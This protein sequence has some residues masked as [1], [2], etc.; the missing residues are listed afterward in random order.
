MAKSRKTTTRSTR[1]DTAPRTSAAERT[2]VRRVEADTADNG[3]PLKGIIIIIL[4]ILGLWL[5]FSLVSGWREGQNGTDESANNNEDA[6]VEDSEG[7]TD[8]AAD[9]NGADAD[10]QPAAAGD[11]A[12]ET[13]VDETDDGYAYTVG[14]GESYTTMARRA[15][16]SVDGNLSPAER[17]AAETKLT[18][19]AGGEWLNAGQDLSL[20]KDTVRAAVDWAKG[21]SDGEKAAWQPYADLV[22]W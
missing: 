18:Q 12:V 11:Q 22:A 15:V 3:S 4:L 6:R 13:T 9:E 20:T 17:V 19:D 8:E 10:Q 5:L 21:L 1:K 14:T 2:R 16:A 7:E